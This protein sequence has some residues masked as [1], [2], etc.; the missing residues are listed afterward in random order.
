M[1]DYQGLTELLRQ[2]S[3]DPNAT[4]EAGRINFS[5]N[6][7]NERGAFGKDRKDSKHYTHPTWMILDTLQGM[8]PYEEPKKEKEKISD[9]IITDAIKS[10]LKTG[11]ESLDP[12]Y[13]NKA[14]SEAINSVL[15]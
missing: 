14:I 5:G 3:A 1:K 9:S 6:Y 15:G 8:T 7:A 10:R 4:F 13:K 2:I 12:E 11:W